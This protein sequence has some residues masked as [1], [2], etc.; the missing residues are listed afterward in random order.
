MSLQM[1][2]VLN[3]TQT[4]IWVAISIGKSISAHLFVYNLSIYLSIYLYDNMLNMFDVIN[5]CQLLTNW[6][7]Y[8]RMFLSLF[9]Q[10]NG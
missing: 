10:P 1:L 6:L 4:H 3:F 8:A 5:D 9:G 2:G 7:W